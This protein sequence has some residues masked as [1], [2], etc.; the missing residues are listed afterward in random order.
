MGD[1][2]EGAG[3]R[4]R[5]LV[6]DGID[7]CGKSTQARLLVAALHAPGRPL[8]L[9]L[10]EPGSTAAGER[11][12]TVLLDPRLTL[13]PAAEALLFVAARRQMLDELVR[14][15]LLAGRDVVCERFHAATYAYQGVAGGIDEAALLALLEEWAGD[16]APDLT[17][18]LDL[19]PAAAALRQ[20]EARD[21][22]E[23]RGLAF[24]RRVAAGFRRYGAARAR[25]VLVDAA[26]T[27]DEVAERVLAEVRRGG[28]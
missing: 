3:R 6:L 27:V 21:R 11:I 4:G 1:G 9:H 2:G 20:G 15:A 13:G 14:P 28:G 7:G 25:V 8:P 19:D 18:V 26:G 23:A 5:F 24:Q 17:V 22:I 16:P 10:R 12:R